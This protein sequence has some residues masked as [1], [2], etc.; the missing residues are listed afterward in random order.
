M[1]PDT[2]AILVA[3]AAA[4]GNDVAAGGVEGERPDSEALALTTLAMKHIE[5]FR[6]DLVWG[7]PGPAG[8]GQI[9]LR[10]KK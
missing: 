8:G 1:V 5:L 2:N 3:L 4:A 7:W 9:H 10:K 6:L